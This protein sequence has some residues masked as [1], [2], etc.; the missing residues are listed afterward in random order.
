MMDY[1]Y[2]NFVKSLLRFIIV[3]LRIYYA[4]AM[5]PYS[6]AIDSARLCKK[7]IAL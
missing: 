5:Y 3:L 2:V 7:N 4:S 1:D 6:S